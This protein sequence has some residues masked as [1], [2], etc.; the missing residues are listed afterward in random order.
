MKA[1]PINCKGLISTCSCG[2][3]VHITYC[4]GEYFV[5]CENGCNDIPAC[6]HTNMNYTIREWN[7]WIIRHPLKESKNNAT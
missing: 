1:M 3:Q 6:F 2:G 7:E 5:V 4:C